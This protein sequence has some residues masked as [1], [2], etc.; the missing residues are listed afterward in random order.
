MDV[1]DALWP[2]IPKETVVRPDKHSRRLGFRWIAAGAPSIIGATSSVSLS[3][4]VRLGSFEILSLLGA[5][6]MGEVYKARG[7]RLDRTA[8]CKSQGALVRPYGRERPHDN[9]ARHHRIDGARRAVDLVPTLILVG[10]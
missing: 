7:M 2:F 6:G 8:A 10:V 9:L 4:G 3:P 1:V 5:G